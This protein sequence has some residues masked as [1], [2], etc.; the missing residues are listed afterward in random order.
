MRSGLPA[1]RSKGRQASLAHVLPRRCLYIFLGNEKNIQ[2]KR[3]QIFVPSEQLSRSASDLIP[4]NGIPD[5]SARDNGHPGMAEVVR[6]KDQ[7]KIFTSGATAFFIKI[8]KIFFLADPLARTIAFY[9]QTARRFRPF[10]L[11][12]LMTFCPLFVLMR[13]KNPW[14]FFLF[15]LFGWNVGFIF[16]FPLRKVC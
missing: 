10:C 9:H 7:V 11:R 5:F 13:T 12:L 15:L 14:S 4:L 1:D 6:K 16:C 8:R 3:Q 2:R